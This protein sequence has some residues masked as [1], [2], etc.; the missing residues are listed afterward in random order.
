MKQSSKANRLSH[1]VALSDSEKKR[2]LTTALPAL[3]LL[4][5]ALVLPACTGAVDGGAPA[6]AAEVALGR[7]VVVREEPPEM[8][9]TATSV[10]L[11]PGAQ[12]PKSILRGTVAGMI[13]VK[14]RPPACATT[15]HVFPK[16]TWGD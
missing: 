8:R 9:A 14:P 1:P 11:G 4:A 13:R 2:V 5:A 10:Q 6:L 7:R 16:N 3:G 15:N 12:R